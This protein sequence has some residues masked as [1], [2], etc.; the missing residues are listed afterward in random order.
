MKGEGG[1]KGGRK[2]GE[3]REEEEKGA[4]DNIWPCPQ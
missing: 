2:K 3:G 1:R 4:G